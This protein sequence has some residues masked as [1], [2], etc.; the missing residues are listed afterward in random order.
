MVV[1]LRQWPM[2]ALTSLNKTFVT[3]IPSDA[4][5]ALLNVSDERV[6]FPISPSMQADVDALHYTGFLRVPGENMLA[7]PN[8]TTAAAS[9]P[10]CA[11]GN[12]T[13]SGRRLRFVSNLERCLLAHQEECRADPTLAAARFYKQSHP[14]DEY[15]FYPGGTGLGENFASRTGTLLEPQATY[16]SFDVNATAAGGVGRFDLFE[17]NHVSSPVRP[18]E[19]VHHPPIGFSALSNPTGEFEN[20][21]I[22]L[23]GDCRDLPGN[24]ERNELVLELALQTVS[25]G[26]SAHTQKFR[27][28]AVS[29]HTQKFQQKPLPPT[30]FCS[31]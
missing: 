7:S 6:P 11:S 23:R 16:F 27:A 12:F 15:P 10:A 2:T 26:V 3:N 22:P 29:T 4:C 18:Q 13:R 14:G 28:S 8:T 30:F 5:G 20:Q 19:V 31:L 1:L 9:S 24:A 25:A 17:P 21:F